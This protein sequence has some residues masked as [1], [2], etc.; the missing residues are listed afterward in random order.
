MFNTRYIVIGASS[1]IG[2]IFFSKFRKKIK[3]ASSNT[4]TVSY[5]NKFNINKNNIDKLIIKYNPTHVII[6]SAESDP[7][8]CFKKPKYSCKKN[9]LFKK[10][11]CSFKSNT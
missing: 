11:A 5:L 6:F 8:K 1:K 4:A 2:K 10:K 7:N 3:F 9:R